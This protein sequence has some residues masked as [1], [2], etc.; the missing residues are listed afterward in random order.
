MIKKNEQ[1]ELMKTIVSL[2]L[3]II[4]EGVELKE[5]FSKMS[6]EETHLAKRKFRKLKRK[7]KKIHYGRQVSRSEIEFFLRAEAAKRL[8]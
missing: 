6:E 3:G 2:D 7:V 4:P 5:A 8:Q 1:L